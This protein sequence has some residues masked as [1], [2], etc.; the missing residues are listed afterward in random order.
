MSIA[1]AWTQC[2]AYLVTRLRQVWPDVVLYFRSNCGFGSPVMCDLCERLRVCYTF[3]LSANS[4]FQRE[5]ERLLAEA[6]AAY[7]WAAGL[8]R[9]L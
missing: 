2:L 7:I 3:G 8:R 4:I 9:R 5:S 6:V 1:P